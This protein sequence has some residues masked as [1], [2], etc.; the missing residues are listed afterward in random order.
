[1]F[2]VNTLLPDF[3][4]ILIG[5]LLYRF[6][7]WGLAFWTG[8]EKLVYFVLFPSLLFY[9]T[10]HTAFDFSISGKLLQA[11]LLTTTVGMILGWL[12]KPLFQVGPMIF[13]SGVQT[14]FRFNSYIALAIGS[15]LAGEKGTSLMAL[16]IGFTLP[17]CNIAAVHA[18]SHKRGGLLKALV[19]NPLLIATISGVLLN[20]SRL[21]L[22]EAANALL[23]RLGNSSI[24]LGLVMVGAGLRLKEGPRFYGLTTYFITVKLIVLP[25]VAYFIGRA[26]MLPPLHLQL[27]VVFCALPTAS[28]S[29]VLAARMGGN[30]PFVAFL[31]SAGTLLS[32]LTLPLWLF[33]VS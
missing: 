26:L 10:S 16:M 22:P 21:H 14:A 32:L 19:K 15:R 27:L 11:V 5:F 30:G 29:Y 8:L 6:T 4:L 31:V 23:S 12:A 9:A 33:L 2:I 1:M 13:E 20:I 18:L 24:A 25:I 28:S 3:T 7:N 17:F